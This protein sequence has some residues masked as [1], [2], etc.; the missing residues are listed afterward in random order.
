MPS[1]PF[2]T[3]AI[4]QTEKAL[5]AILRRQLSGTPLSEPGWVILTLA[6]RDDGRLDAAAFTT[7]M[8]DMLHVAPPRAEA[9][10]AGLR[11]AGLLDA[12]PAV[13]VT[14]AGRAL[15]ARIRTATE[16]ITARLWGDLPAEDLAT[17]GRVLAIVHERASRELARQP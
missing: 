17:A 14:E 1:T 11:A 8:A 3:Q 2:G 16:A 15:H 9:E 13:T 7:H 5:D 12:E 6:L 4:G 10:I